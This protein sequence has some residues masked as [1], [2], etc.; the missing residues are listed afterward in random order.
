MATLFISDLHLHP[1]RP[2]INECFL[3]FLEDVR[4][5]ARALY[6]L[7]D[8][9]EAWVGDDHPEASYAPVK[10]A[11]ARCNRSGTPVFLLHGNRDFL[12]GNQFAAETGCSLLEDP[13]RIDLYGSQALLMHGDTL[14]TD[15][16]DYQT[17]RAR[18][19]DPEWQRQ[20]LVLP[21]KERLELAA[22]A[23]ELS[24]LSTDAKDA[25]IM[26][27]NQQEVLR[28]FARHD[29]SLLI[30]GHTHRP[31]IH[32]LEYAGRERRRIVLG[33]WYEQ[34]SVLSVEDGKLEL[35]SLPA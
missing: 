33:A 7:G 11:L 30:H 31:G 19:R 4:G 26:D 23:R 32:R 28:M 20:A 35:R 25:A 2:A 29:V 5:N 12:L 18:V 6:I 13:V 1:A 3:R 21:L 15:D 8:L 17:L 16:T 10:Q 24:A 14:C 27:V 9:F 34:G 22:Q